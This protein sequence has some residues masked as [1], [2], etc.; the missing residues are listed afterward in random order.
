MSLKGEN[1]AVRRRLPPFDKGSGGLERTFG[2]W[3]LGSW[4]CG[5]G[6]GFERALSAPWGQQ[7]Y[8]HIRLLKLGVQGKRADRERMRKGQ[9]PFA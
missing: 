2:F 6:A 1:K 5:S 3:T 9:A 8:Q 7:M 4:T